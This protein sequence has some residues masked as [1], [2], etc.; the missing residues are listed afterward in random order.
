MVFVGESSPMAL[1]QVSEI[2]QFTQISGDSLLCWVGRRIFNLL[3]WIFRRRP[4]EHHLRKE[5]IAG[6]TNDTTGFEVPSS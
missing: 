2:F 3:R 1:V 4:N 6:Q 5:L